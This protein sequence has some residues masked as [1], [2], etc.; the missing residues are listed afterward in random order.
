MNCRVGC[1][2][3]CIALSISSPIPGMPDG[4]PAGV[5]CVQLTDDNRCRLFGQPERPTVCQNLRPTPEMC[6]E[7]REEA[8]LYLAWLEHETAPE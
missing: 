6:G 5:R 3:C 7:N 4:K 2:A 8:L 1:G